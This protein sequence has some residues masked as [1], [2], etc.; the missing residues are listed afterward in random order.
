MDIVL[1]KVQKDIAKEARRFLKK[2]CT[3]EYV[4]DLLDDD[5]G[6]HDDLWFKMADMGWMSIRIPE[7]YG[8]MGMDQTD[9]NVVLEEMGRALVPGPFFSTVVLAA[10]II[11][12]CGDERQKKK[13][14]PGIADGRVTG[15]LAIYEPDSGA[16][17]DYI[18]MEAQ[19]KDNGYVLDGT[20]LF[21][22]DA[23]TAGFIICA[24]RTEEDAIT[25]FL[26]DSRAEGISISPMP[27][28]DGTRRMGV[29]DI[30]NL[31]VAQDNVLGESDKGHKPLRKVMQRAQTGLCAETLGGAERSMEI[32]VWHAKNRIQFDQPIGAFQSIKHRCAQMYL[33][34]ESSRSLL[35]WA[36]WA[37]DYAEPNE[38]AVAA[39]TAKAFCSETGKNV[40][41]SAI[42]VLGA[43]GFSWESDLHLYFKRSR[44]NDVALGDSVF[45]REQIVQLITNNHG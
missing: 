5:R 30:S 44:A 9:L 8:G 16:D 11:M 1:N 28:M 7:K 2:E 37:Q 42:Q 35:Y 45:H 25:L 40:T 18:R 12:E 19:K 13:Y 14:L 33:E 43:N 10:E 21:V 15:T 26:L 17:P 29:L 31:Y 20:K 36:G 39:S 4:R 41:S 22:P 3:I 6:Y 32:A 38:A 34:I 24:A 27:T 23:H